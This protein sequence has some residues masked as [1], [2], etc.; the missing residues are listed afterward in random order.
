M[1]FDSDHWAELQALFHLAAETP[2]DERERVLSAACSD[3][4]VLRRAL[5]ILAAAERKRPH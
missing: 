1:S 5:E 2:E 4:D 3:Q